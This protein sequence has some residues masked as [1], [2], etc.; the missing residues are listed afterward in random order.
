M[1]ITAPAATDSAG[2]VQGC[3]AASRRL[4]WEYTVAFRRRHRNHTPSPTLDI[5]ADQLACEHLRTIVPVVL[6]RHLPG[7]RLVEWID[8]HPAVID[9][10]W[11]APTA[12]TIDLYWD[13]R[14]DWIIGDQTALTVH[15]TS[16]DHPS[17]QE[18]ARPKHAPSPTRSEPTPT[19][20]TTS[21]PQHCCSPRP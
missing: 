14:S 15:A 9:S 17:Q 7:V 1:T 19:A 5:E 4:R 13:Y 18:A 2:I 8:P 6:A 21:R 16:P 10:T 3:E 12:W 11:H 20:S